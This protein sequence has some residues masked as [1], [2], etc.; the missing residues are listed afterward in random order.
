MTVFH[1]GGEPNKQK[2]NFNREI[3]N[4]V[5]AYHFTGEG[6][7]L[8]AHSAEARECT[9]HHL[10]YHTHYTPATTRLPYHLQ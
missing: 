5:E 6:Y 9:L 7:D 4:K 1:G 10:S 8:I 3:F 2:I